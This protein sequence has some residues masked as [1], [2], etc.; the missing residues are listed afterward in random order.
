D[1]SKFDQKK[2]IERELQS[3]LFCGI[4]SVR[5]AGDSVD[6]TLKV[7]KLFGSGERLGTELFMCGP[8]FTAEGGHG[9]EYGKFLPEAARADFIAQFVRTPKSADEA[10]KQVDALVAQRVDAIKGVLE[11]GAPGYSFNRMDVNILRAVTE[12]AHAK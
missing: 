1:W 8:L 3:Y 10:R 9:T 7:R 5:S 12:E 11:A 6:D 2:A 4:T